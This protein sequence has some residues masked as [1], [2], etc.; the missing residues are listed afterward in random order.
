MID[1]NPK[2][3]AF[4]A[5]Y[6]Q[7]GNVT[8]AAKIAGVNRSTHYEWLKCDQYQARFSEAHEEAADALEAEARRRALSG[9]DRPI[10]QRG[11]QVG[12]VREYSD[13][14]LIFLLKAT[15]PEKFRERFD[16]RLSGGEGGPIKMEI[17]EELVDLPQSHGEDHQDNPA[18]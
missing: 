10:F 12:V 9:V 15:R 4:L 7:V 8:A 16:H 13:T 11:Q 5:A 18:P 17:V 2:Q 6:A 1:R 14:L 3:E